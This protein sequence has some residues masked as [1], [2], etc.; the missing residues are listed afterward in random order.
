MKNLIWAV[1][2]LS[3][4]TAL[5]VSFPTTSVAVPAVPPTS[6][7]ASARAWLS[8]RTARPSKSET[9]TARDRTGTRFVYR[10]NADGNP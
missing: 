6:P 4:A 5:A 7:R 2:A 3:V 8:S 1:G 9:S 10:I